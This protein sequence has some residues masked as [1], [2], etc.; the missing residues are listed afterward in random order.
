MSKEEMN[1]KSAEL[2]GVLQAISVVAKKL[3]LRIARLQEEVKN[4]EKGR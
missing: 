2:I 3:A 1:Q 4:L